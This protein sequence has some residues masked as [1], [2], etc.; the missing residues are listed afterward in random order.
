[1]KNKL[2]AEILVLI[3][4]LTLGTQISYAVDFDQGNVD[5]ATFDQILQPLMKIYSFI[6]YA[7]S[8]IAGIVL[9]LAGLTY[10]TSGGDPGKREKAKSMA[11]FV[12]VGLIV[13]WATPLIVNYVAA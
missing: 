1:M 11:T 6:K 13:I 5:T 12:V 10:M 7:A 3:L 9:L 4:A 2:P 8:A